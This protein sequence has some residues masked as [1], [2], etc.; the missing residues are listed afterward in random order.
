VIVSSVTVSVDSLLVDVVV[1]DVSVV[2]ADA[3]STTASV[4]DEVSLLDA[5][6][7]S[8]TCS[9]VGVEVGVVVGV[10][11]EISITGSGESVESVTGSL[12]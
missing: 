4:V 5:V 12:V 7:S 3:S 11:V 2:E 6:S 8:V 10:E 1:P 9:A